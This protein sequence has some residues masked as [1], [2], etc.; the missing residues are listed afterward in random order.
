[1]SIDLDMPTKVFVLLETCT[2]ASTYLLVALQGIV[3][4]C[5]LILPVYEVINTG[6]LVDNIVGQTQTALVDIRSES[7]SRLCKRL[8]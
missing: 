6:G 2:A 8:A 7:V 3:I 5:V 1:M 4:C